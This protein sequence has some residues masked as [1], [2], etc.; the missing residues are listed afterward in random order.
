MPSLLP[1]PTFY[2]QP[3]TPREL[4]RASADTASSACGKKKRGWCAAGFGLLDSLRLAFSSAALRSRRRR[5][6]LAFTIVG[7]VSAVDALGSCRLTGV[8]SALGQA[9]VTFPGLL[10][11]EPAWPRS[12]LAPASRVSSRLSRLDRSG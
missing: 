9:G 11:H 2:A 5:L 12:R 1:H 3:T 4:R 6:K 7:I 10:A 8:R